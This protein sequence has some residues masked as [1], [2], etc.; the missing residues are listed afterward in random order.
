[1][2]KLGPPGK[3]PGPVITELPG[4]EMKGIEFQKVPRKKASGI[5]IRRPPAI[6]KKRRDVFGK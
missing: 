2:E 3:M 1:V 5:H 4:R 6:Q